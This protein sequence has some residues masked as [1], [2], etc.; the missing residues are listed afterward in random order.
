MDAIYPCAVLGYRSRPS[1]FDKKILLHRQLPD[2][3]VKRLD[4]FVALV[5]GAVAAS[6][7]SLS[8]GLHELSL[9]GLYLV[10]VQFETFGELGERAL[11]M[12]GGQG[13]LY[14]ERRTMGSACAS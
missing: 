5:R 13:Y 9:P 3:Y 14:L 6:S 8:D 12:N 1:A 11:A 2:L 7:E 10:R 4:L